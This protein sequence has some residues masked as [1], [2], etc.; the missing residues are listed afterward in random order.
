MTYLLVYSKEMDVFL[1][2]TETLN[3]TFGIKNDPNDKR[4]KQVG[5]EKQKTIDVLSAM[6]QFKFLGDLEEKE[7][8]I[9]D[10][11]I[12]RIKNNYR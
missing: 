7:K 4:A 11:L 5:F 1:R 3:L 8:K 10:T 6:I 2:A 12:E 9:L